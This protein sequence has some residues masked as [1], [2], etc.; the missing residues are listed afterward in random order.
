[1][2]G[3]GPLGLGAGLIGVSESFLV[4][5]LV[6]FLFLVPSFGWAGNGSTKNFKDK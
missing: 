4:I 3:W 6:L 2:R 5:L 1:M